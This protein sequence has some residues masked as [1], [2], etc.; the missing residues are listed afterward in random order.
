MSLEWGDQAVRCEASRQHRRL[1]ADQV[2]CL[3]VALALYRHQSI[4]EVQDDRDL[5]LRDLY[6]LRV[7]KNATAQS[8]AAPGC[9][10]AAGFA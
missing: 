9:G 3:V 1:P 7:I 2:A 5:A 6:T 10:A 8:P 4:S